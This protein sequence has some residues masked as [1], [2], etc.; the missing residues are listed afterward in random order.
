MMITLFEIHYKRLIEA[1]SKY[2]CNRAPFLKSRM[3]EAIDPAAGRL[4]LI[5]AAYLPGCQV[6]KHLFIRQPGG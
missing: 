3:T 5:T 4:R 6:N 1:I 2:T